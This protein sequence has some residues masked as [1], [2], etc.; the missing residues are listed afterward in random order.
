MTDQ[1]QIQDWLQLIR[2]EYAELPDLRLTQVQVQQLWRLA[3][4]RAEAFMN[5][6]VSAGVLRKTQDGA[7]VRAT[8]G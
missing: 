5:A 2:A 7:Y 8:S 1:M 3:A 6:L 4:T